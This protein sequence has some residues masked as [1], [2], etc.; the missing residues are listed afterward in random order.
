[1]PGMPSIL[2]CT[3]AQEHHSV[4]RNWR[5]ADANRQRQVQHRLPAG[6]LLHRPGASYYTPVGVA[7]AVGVA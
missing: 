2:S 7:G 5:V 6:K 4:Y 3:A 1:M